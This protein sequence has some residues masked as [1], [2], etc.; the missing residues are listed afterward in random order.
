[1]TQYGKS[2]LSRGAFKPT[3]YAFFDD[4]I[5][6]DSQYCSSGSSAEYEPSTQASDRIRKSVRIEPQYNY[7]GVETNIAKS[8]EVVTENFF[9]GFGA[10]FPITY[11]LSIQKS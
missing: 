10:S 3:H 4:D 8:S 11:E 5:I 9:G 7:A 2:L 6:Y 1:M